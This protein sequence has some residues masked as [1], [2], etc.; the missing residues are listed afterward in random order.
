MP[1]RALFSGWK[2]WFFTFIEMESGLMKPSRSGARH[3]Y[4]VSRPKMRFLISLYK[5][6]NPV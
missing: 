5:M 1:H 4:S 3:P 6:V 2:I